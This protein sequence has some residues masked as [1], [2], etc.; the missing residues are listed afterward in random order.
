MTKKHSK[1]LTHKIA[2]RLLYVSI[3][4]SCNYRRILINLMHHFSFFV[5]IKNRNDLHMR[6]MYERQLIYILEN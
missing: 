3:L 6:R 2:N 4:V 5:F 1:F